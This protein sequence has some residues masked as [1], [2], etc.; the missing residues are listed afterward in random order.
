MRPVRLT[1][2]AFGPYAKREVIDFRAAIEAGLF[3]IYGKTGSGK[4]TIFSAMTFALFGQPARSEQE[5]LSLRSDHADPGTPT[6]IEL[7]FEVGGKRFVVLRRPDQMRPKQRGE[8]EIRDAHEAWIFDATGL[9]LDEI[10][11]K[12][13]GKIIA[14]KKVREVD[15][16]IRDILGY[17]PEQFRQIVLLPQGRFETF[18]SAKTKERLEILRELFDVSLYQKLMADL[19]SEAETAERHVRTER[20]ICARRLSAEGFESTDALIAGIADAEKERTQ[21]FEREELAR[22]ACMTARAALQQGQKLEE[23]FVTCERAQKIFADLEMHKDRADAL[24]ERVARAERASS[25]LDMESFVSETG[26]EAAEAENK[27]QNA[28]AIAEQ[29]RQKAA[30]AGEALERENLRAAEMDELHRKIDE[31]TRFGEAIERAKGCADMVQKAETAEKEAVNRLNADLKELA[32]RQQ[33]R[34]ERGEGLKLARLSETRRR[35]ISARVT[36][37]VMA[38][39]MARSYEKA[40]RDVAQA[41]QEIDEKSRSYDNA[42]QNAEEARAKLGEAEHNLLAAQ[43]LHLA[44]KLEDGAPCPVCGALEH[45]APAIGSMENPGLERAISDART[46]WEAADKAVQSVAQLFAGARSV[47][48]EREGVLANLERPA[49]SSRELTEDIETEQLALDGLG[50][51]IDIAAAEAGYEKSGEEVTRCE[52]QRDALREVLAERRQEAAA[53]RARLDEMLGA[54]PQALRAPDALTTAKARVSSDFAALQAARVAAEKAVNETREAAFGAQKDNESAIETLSVCQERHRRAKEAF[55]GRLSEAG[56]SEEAYRDLKPAIANR[57]ADRERVEEYRR[58]LENAREVA[59]VAAAEVEV[60]E[61]PDIKFLAETSRTAEEN[62]L[63]VT[64]QHIAAESRVDHLTRLRD[65]LAENLRRLDEAE[66]ASGP[67]RALAALV[68]G[69]NPQKLS[70]ETFAIGAMFDQVLEAAN[71]RLGPMTAERY[72][73][74]RDIEGGRGSRGLGIQVF[75]MHT[76]KSRSTTTLSGGETFI[77]ALALALGLADVVES[78]SGKVRLDTIFIDEG[79]GSLDTENGSG[80]LD[81]VLQILNKLVSQNR[82]VGLISHVT[83]VQEAIP[84]GFYVNNGAGGGRVEERGLN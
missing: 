42:V 27:L 36:N 19:K 84:N 61:R 68:N 26:R 55:Y 77:A 8:G 59:I 66:A 12:Q 32:L 62:L 10:T 37:L 53:L 5:T 43:A 75:D 72:R 41:R 58:K 56:F 38:Q 67:L 7:V 33:S 14:E 2:Q 11:E 34:F 49:R 9:P 24:A 76:G 54:V 1:L 22:S 45:P 69:N 82:A 13:R 48:A 16:A 39:V 63:E 4:S 60:L 83:L 31:L 17:G 18:L 47:L 51:T 65:S 64:R 29:A 3:G 81:Q 74:E 40:E 15:A 25:L 70:L 52:H 79:F 80:T 57:V 73:L 28:Q 21:L 71:L 46:A 6:E 30:A 23:K 78:A 35:E 20:E 50:P 44:S